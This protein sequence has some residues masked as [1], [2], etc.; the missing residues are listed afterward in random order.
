MNLRDGNRQNGRGVPQGIAVMGPGAGV[1]EN[2][3]NS[4][5][6]RLMDLLSDRAFVIRLE[7]LDGAAEFFP[8]HL[9]FPIDLIQGDCPV[10]DR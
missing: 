3:I 1:D 10:L 4:L 9:Q 5:L 8:Q 7:G 6:V 2:G